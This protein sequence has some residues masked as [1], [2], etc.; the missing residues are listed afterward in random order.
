[1]FGKGSLKGTD[2]IIQQ[3]NVQ[4]TEYRRQKSAKAEQKRQQEEQLKREK[5][6][7]D[8]E[9]LESDKDLYRLTCEDIEKYQR[10]LENL[11]DGFYRDRTENS[12]KSSLAEKQELEERFNWA[13][14]N[15]VEVG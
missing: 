10:E 11:E 9:G 6:I 13:G 7:H 8:P 1:M 15:V 3:I 4:D 14:V 12:L 5:Y 2:E